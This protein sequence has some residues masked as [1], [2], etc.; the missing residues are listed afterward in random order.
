MFLLVLA[1]LPPVFYWFIESPVQMVLAGGLAQAAMLPL[2]GIAAIY[3]RHRHVPADI[4][5]AMGTTVMLWIATVVMVGFALYYVGARQVRAEAATL[6]SR[7][8]HISAAGN[9]E[10]DTRAARYQTTLEASAGFVALAPVRRVL[11]TLTMTDAVS[12]SPLA[13]LIST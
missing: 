11:R 7:R 5:P 9:G 3:L 1:V 6:D 2:I 10:P 13:F 12:H 8:I 4:Q